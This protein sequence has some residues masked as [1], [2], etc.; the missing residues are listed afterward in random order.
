MGKWII[1]IGNA[2]FSLDAIKPMTFEGKIDVREYGE[3]QFDVLFQEGYV[4]FLFDHDGMIRNDFSSE[5]LKDLPYDEPQ[6]VL[7]KYSEKDL[8]ERVITSTD[9][10]KDVLIDCDG[11][12]LGLEQ[13]FD[14]S[15]LL[16]YEE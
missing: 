11:V 1:L 12:D 6:F 10:P 8:V 7:M 13:F 15:R 3:K 4:S 14:K 16:H 9:F 5:E 2:G